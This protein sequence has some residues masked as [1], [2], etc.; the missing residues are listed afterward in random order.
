MGRTL[1]KPEAESRYTTLLMLTT[2]H[3]N[4]KKW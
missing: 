1:Y 4:A 3:S 2:D